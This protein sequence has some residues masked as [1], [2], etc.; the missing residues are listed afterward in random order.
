MNNLLV[1]MEFD[2]ML[3]SASAVTQTGTEL[4]TKYKMYTMSNPVNYNLVNNFIKEANA[5]KYD[6]GVC[7]ILESVADFVTS[8]KTKWALATACESIN[9]NKS[10]F[11][12]LQRHATKQVDKLLEMSED[13]VVKYIKAG[14]LK[15]VMFCESLRNI[16]KQVYKDQPIIEAAADYTVVHPISLIENVGDGICFEVMGTIYKVDDSKNIQEASASEVSNVFKNVSSL[17]ESKYA[18]Y[19]NQ[20]VTVSVNNSKYEISEVNKCT[21]ITGDKKIELTVEQLRDNN[22]LVLMSSNKANKVLYNQL[23]YLLESI[24]QLCEN[25]DN[26]VNLDNV[27]IYHTKTDKF[28]VFESN[29]KLFATLLQ[30]VKYQK[31]TIFENAVDALS[32]IKTK[33]NVNLSDRYKEIVENNLEQATA[34]EKARIQEELKEQEINSY[35]NRIEALTEKFKNDPVKLAVLSSL[36]ESLN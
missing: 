4:L 12:Y 34:Q 8:N 16:A 21:K 3:N 36:A 9:N 17:L 2:A 5:C 26:V 24:A 14:A 6:A 32:F 29:D 18:S 30:S 11:N 15:N 1:E 27:S 31:W 35:R 20:V 7:K 13:D 25:Y 22:R 10:S 28:M 33:T 19:D 23:A